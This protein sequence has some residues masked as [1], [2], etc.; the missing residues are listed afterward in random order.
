MDDAA[1]FDCRQFA[2]GLMSTVAIK[3]WCPGALRPML[4][5]DGLVVRVRPHGGRLSSAQAAGIAELST[6]FG[7]GLIDVTNRAN[8][9]LRGIT[10][11]THEPLMQALARFDLL[12]A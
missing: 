11:R 10:D 2:R 8:L 1:Q 3:G 7:N 4:S 9:Q 6:R 5:G 12:D